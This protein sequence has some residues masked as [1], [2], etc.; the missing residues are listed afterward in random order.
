MYRLSMS[1]ARQR[2][3]NRFAAS[4][5]RPR[6][7]FNNIQT[8]LKRGKRSS[9]EHRE[10]LKIDRFHFYAEKEV[11][12][13]VE[14][15]SVGVALFEFFSCRRSG[16]LRCHR[17]STTFAL[18][19]IEPSE[20][21]FF[22]PFQ[23]FDQLTIFV[24]VIDGETFPRKNLFSNVLKKSLLFVGLHLFQRGNEG[25]QSRERRRNRHG[26]SLIFESSKNVV[27]LLDRRVRIED[28]GVVLS[29]SES[30]RLKRDDGR[31]RT[32]EE[33][34]DVFFR[35]ELM[36]RIGSISEK[37]RDDVDQKS[38]D[39]QSIVFIQGVHLK[40]T[41]SERRIC[42]S[43]LFINSHS[44]RR[45]LDHSD[46]SN[47]PIRKFRA[48]LWRPMNQPLMATECIS[49]LVSCSIPRHGL[50][51][52]SDWFHWE[53]EESSNWSI[54]VNNGERKEDF[55][56]RNEKNIPALSILVS[57][58]LSMFDNIDANDPIFSSCV[59][60]VWSCLFLHLCYTWFVTV[61]VLFLP[62]MLFVQI[63]HFRWRHYLCVNRSLEELFLIEEDHSRVDDLRQY[64]IE[65]VRVVSTYL[66]AVV[67]FTLLLTNHS[68]GWLTILRWM[69]EASFVLSPS[70]MSFF[71]FISMLGMDPIWL[72]PIRQSLL[73]CHTCW[74]ELYFYGCAIQNSI[75]LH[76]WT[77]FTHLSFITIVTHLISPVPLLIILFV[78]CCIS[79][80]FRTRSRSSGTCL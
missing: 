67:G 18:G 1:K 8:L 25:N 46:D 43:Y 54:D 58:I 78:V 51:R 2:H 70:S 27:Q 31:W 61:F 73:V 6:R 5:H 16:S 12:W 9:P 24:F 30:H 34:V 62:V 59:Q 56:W 60:T 19:L 15:D 80:A 23:Q 17:D 38:E 41:E 74:K 72:I 40:T 77:T 66:S 50:I 55:V 10:H 45:N 33:L 22:E 75:H 68:I 63:G 35:Q 53:E 13:P 65:E 14:F 47:R 48:R 39:H 44:R 71:L 79:H 76:H 69:I 29:P 3:V 21:L 20:E 4:P 49:A 32:A 57:F 26:I 52:E 11:D 7:V 36:S 28:K 42:R 64:L 37:I